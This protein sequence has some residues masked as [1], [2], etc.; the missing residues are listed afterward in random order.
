MTAA[1]QHPMDLTGV[2]LLLRP[3]HKPPPPPPLTCLTGVSQRRGLKTRNWNW[4]GQV[5]RTMRMKTLISRV[6]QR[7][8]NRV[9]QSSAVVT[10]RKKWRFEIL[11]RIFPDFFGEV[12]N[13]QNRKAIWHPC[14]YHTYETEQFPYGFH[15]ESVC[16]ISMTFAACSS[17][18]HATMHCCNE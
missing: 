2:D 4:T 8:R 17:R 1:L 7:L 16:P 18:W 12:S 6:R 11:S 3:R 14:G 10:F 5:T 13:Y 15:L 9:S